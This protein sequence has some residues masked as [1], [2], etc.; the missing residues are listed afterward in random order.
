[1]LYNTIEVVK[2]VSM[3]K[4]SFC[5]VIRNAFFLFKSH[6]NPWNFFPPLSRK[7]SFRLWDE[8]FLFTRYLMR[9]TETLFSV[10]F[11][12]LSYGI[13]ISTHPKIPQGSVKNRAKKPP[14]LEKNF[15]LKTFQKFKRLIKRKEWLALHWPYGKLQ[16]LADLQS[17]RE[18]WT[19]W[20]FH[21]SALPPFHWPHLKHTQ[22]SDAFL[23][24][25]GE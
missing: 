11:L 21:C 14:D 24:Q 9:E 25:K 7:F 4:L 19:I 5:P 20:I 13:L 23:V 16:F 22:G 12:P 2:I 8:R 17:L 10:F 1:M 15:N 18:F 6:G 3:S